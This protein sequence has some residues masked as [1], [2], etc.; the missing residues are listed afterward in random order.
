MGRKIIG[1]LPHT[2]FRHQYTRS[3]WQ[4][5]NLAL[6]FTPLMKDITVKLLIKKTQYKVS[7]II[8]LFPLSFI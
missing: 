5:K 6:I 7:I 1:Y 8:E 3:R 2:S 4:G